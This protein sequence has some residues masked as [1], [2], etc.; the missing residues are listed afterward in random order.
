[1]HSPVNNLFGHTVAFFAARPQL[2]QRRL[3]SAYVAKNTKFCGYG[4]QKHRRCVEDTPELRRGTCGGA[5]QRSSL[6]TGSRVLQAWS[7]GAAAGNR[8]PSPPRAPSVGSQDRSQASQL[9]LGTDRPPGACPEA[10][11]ARARRSPQRLGM[12]GRSRWRPQ[13]ASGTLMAVVPQLAVSP[14]LA[15]RSAPMQTLHGGHCVL[16]DSRATA[17]RA[18]CLPEKPRSTAEEH[19]A[20]ARSMAWPLPLS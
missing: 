20:P 19:P 3:C 6:Y 12:P 10:L 8:R 7:S 17:A 13:P 15:S 1:M 9:C 5:R 4:V 18:R 2:R 16:S 14:A 11:D